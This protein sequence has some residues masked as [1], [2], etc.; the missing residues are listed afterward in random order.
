[1]A[2]AKLILTTMREGGSMKTLAFALIAIVAAAPVT[3]APVT[4]RTFSITGF[5]RIR[6]DGP[7]RVQL[8]TGVAPYARASGTAAALDGVDI[9]VE[10]RTLVVRPSKVSW[11][12]YPGQA[13]GPVSITIGT[14]DLGTAWI[15]GS[16]M[17]DVD[18]IKGL[19]F[20]LSVQGAG[21]AN[22]GNAAVDQ[23]KIGL[24]GSG[25]VRIAGIAPKLTAIVRGTSVLDGTGLNVKDAVIGAEGTPAVR[26]NVSGTAKVDAQGLATVEL[27]GRPACE[28]KATGSANVSGCR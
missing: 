11:G 27:G 18:K 26:A 7:F 17:L 14:H 20:D 16:G 25:T 28:V 22:I 21:S 9:D 2:A 3:A 23:M 12:G 8:A 6:I 13:R 4:S 10:G 15:N 5:D 1:M 19:S 24:S